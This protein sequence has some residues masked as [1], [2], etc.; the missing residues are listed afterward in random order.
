MKNSKK[1]A[2]CGVSAAFGTIF[3]FL[4]RISPTAKLSLF[5][6]SSVAIMLPLSKKI[7]G[8]SALT[9]IAT[10]LLGFIT[11]G[12]TVFLSY[13]LIFGIHPLTNALLKNILNFKGGVIIKTAIKLVYICSVLYL[14]YTIAV[15]AEIFP[16]L[17]INFFPLALIVA[18][19]FIPYDFLMQALQT[20][21]DYIV[22]KYI[23]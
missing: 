18:L 1:I 5:A 17:Q 6:L 15:I 16:Q 21:V 23:K 10:A 7:Y 12:F 4:I 2:L 22:S 11:G 20:K 9:V 14:L 8:G 19:I 13:I 3:L